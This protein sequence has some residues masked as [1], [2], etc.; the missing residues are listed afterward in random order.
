MSRFWLYSEIKTK[1]V[2]DLDLEDEDFI[3]DTEMMAYVNEAIDEAEAEIHSLCEDYFLTRGA[4]TLVSGTDEYSLPSDI[5]A[6]KI[7]GVYYKNGSTVREI[8]R[9]RNWKKLGL[10]VEGLTASASAGDYDYLI[11]NETA[12]APKIVF[13]PTVQESGAYIRIY[14]IRNATRMTTTS[15][16]CDIPEFVSFVIQYA[17]VRCYEKEGHPNLSLALAALEQQR[18]QMTDT[19]SGMVVDD[20]NE[21][22]ADVSFYS[23]HE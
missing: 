12:G 21:I 22:E 23:E 4:I 14:Y 8:K 18:Q 2:N 15:S 10:Y 17:K 6:M 19:L 20:D 11:V 3:S 1:I 13:T 9:L 7:R 16:V 5:Y